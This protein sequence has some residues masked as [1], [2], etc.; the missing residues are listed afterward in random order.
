M[1]GKRRSALRILLAVCVL[2]GVAAF[3]PAGA[4]AP[5]ALRAP[6][7][8]LDPAQCLLPFPNDRFTKA[9]PG[10]DT[11][12]R[13]DFQVAE[14]P[15]GAGVKP[16]D[17]IEWNRNDG[18]SPGSM[19][20]TF[21]PGLDL[22]QTWGTAGMSTGGPNDPADHIAD[23]ARYGA[24]DAP[25]LIIDAATGERWSFWSELDTNALTGDDERLLILRP[26]KNFLEGRRYLVALRNMRDGSGA[27][28][29]A[30]GEFAAI[31]DASGIVEV[32][33]A[34]ADHV[35]GVIAGIGV[36]ETARGNS[37]D[38][39][40]LFLAWDFTIISERS[41][42][43]RVLHIRDDAFAQL[44]DTDL[45]NGVVEGDAPKFTITSVTAQSGTKQRQVEGTITVPYYIDR[46][47][48]PVGPDEVEVP[49]VGGVPN[50]SIPTGRFL[51]GPD[52][53]PM[54]N[55]AI[56]TIEAPFVCTIPTVATASNKAHPM[57]YGHGLLGSRFESAGSSSDRMR[58]RNFMPCAV[59][60]FG[61]AEYDV[62]NALVTL[63]DPSNMASMMDRTQQGFVN[64]LYL[65][66]AL[67]HADGLT[68][69]DAF[70]DAN[71]DPL[72]ESGKLVYDGN[73]Q[74]GIMGG[75]LAALAVDHTRANLGVVGMNYSTLLN[76]SVDWEGP[77]VNPDDPDLPSYSSFLYTMFPDKQQQ[78]IVMGLLQML[79]DRGEANGYAQHMTDNPLPNTPAHRVLL[80]S[81]LGDFQVA[82]VSAEVEARTIG[83][84]FLDSALMSGRHRSVDPGFGMPSMAAVHEGSALIIWDS[85]NYLD[86]N[87]NRPPV[88]TGGDPHE[89]PRRDPRSGDQRAHFFRT[90]QVIDV[91]S[92]A[93]YLTCRPDRT[94]DI[95]RVPIL[96]GFDWC[97]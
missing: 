8:P 11:G 10:T 27:I 26:A 93:P 78:Q 79:W 90:G 17:P 21:V 51:Y 56:P 23:I 9:D 3:A 92:G 41:M 18:F 75:A 19:V 48:Y 61:F 73:S 37:F 57:L 33:Q 38:A 16:I 6:C 72:A 2:A 69:D 55:P 7:D 80:H 74:G 96:F 20:L 36:A 85:G 43:E 50:Q 30:G 82:P 34:R 32:D 4:V 64:F 44:G 97:V 83:A 54:Q 40:D 88:L 89:D 47:P 49:E 39:A 5:P 14:M 28:I 84:A 53:L 12:R 76:R 35:R 95:P 86:P 59:N 94:N 25:I 22:H 70:K 68:S 58:E 60:W 66:R 52:G 65:G 62:A 46:P 91:F 15:R 81:A 24:A 87:G 71:L 67:A 42:T 29:P 77:L 63:V 1:P 13:I 45:A 31:R